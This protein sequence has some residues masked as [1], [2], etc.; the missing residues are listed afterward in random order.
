MHFIFHCTVKR[1]MST[2]YTPVQMEPISKLEREYVSV[3]DLD[4][5][6]IL[7]LAL[8]FQECGYL[9]MRFLQATLHLLRRQERLTYLSRRRL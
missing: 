9:T 2:W 5:A 7:E 3:F 4:D 6:S 1:D 8:A